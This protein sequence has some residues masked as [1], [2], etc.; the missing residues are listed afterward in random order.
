MT[1]ILSFFFS[2]L[3][4]SHPLWITALW[5]TAVLTQ[6][7]VSVFVPLLYCPKTRQ[8]K[9]THSQLD[10]LIGLLL[11]LPHVDQF[12]PHAAVG[13]GRQNPLEEAVKP[14][15][16]SGSFLTTSCKRNEH[17]WISSY[18]CRPDGRSL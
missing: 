1:V 10:T 7:D 5:F 9:S 17:L 12:S 8:M 15:P 18:Q 16:A 4:L 11:A 14:N 2:S 3:I 6:I 13:L